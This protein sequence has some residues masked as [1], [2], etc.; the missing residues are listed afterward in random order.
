[1]PIAQANGCGIYY[2]TTGD[3]HDLVFVHGEDHGIELFSDQLPVFSRDYRC[4]AFYRRG[5]GRSESAPYG[6]S[7]WNQ[8][9]DLRALLEEL[10]I[11]RAVLVGV[12]MG[13]PVAAL[14]AMYRPGAVAGLVMAA[15]YELDGYPLLEERRKQAH[16]L[17]FAQLHLRMHEMRRDQGQAALRSFIESNVD[18]YYPIFPIQPDLRQRMVDMV[19][20][21]P[22]GHYLQAV[23]HYSSLPNLVPEMHRVAA[24]ILGI[25]GSDDPSPDRPELLAHV[26]NFRQEWVDGARRF[27][28]MEQPNA[29][30]AMVSGFLEEVGWTPG[31]HE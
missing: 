6:Y 26:A 21:H 7:L 9:H 11:K 27:V 13:N 20:S 25:C 12:G 22:E 3:G 5:H 17:T 30:N 31:W 8:M 16:Q 14:F 2:E 29:F 19:S 23:E 24:P 18:R 10:G 1:M 15:W 4:T 28:V